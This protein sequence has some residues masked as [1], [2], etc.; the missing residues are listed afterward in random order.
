MELLLI[1]P[2]ASSSGI[3][4]AFGLGLRNYEVYCVSNNRRVFLNSFLFLNGTNNIIVF[5]IIKLNITEFEDGKSNF[6]C[7]RLEVS[8]TL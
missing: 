5:R 1:D 7:E 3:R 6:Q 4:V 2:F 8:E